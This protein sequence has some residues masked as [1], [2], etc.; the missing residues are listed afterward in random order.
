[1]KPVLLD[2]GAIAFLIHLANE[3]RAGEILAVD[4]DFQIYRG[5]RNNHFQVLVS[6][7]AWPLAFHWPGLVLV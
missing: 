4:S 5:E 7:H 3:F 1:M 6:L 2:T